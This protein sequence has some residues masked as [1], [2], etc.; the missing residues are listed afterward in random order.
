MEAKYIAASEAA[1]EQVWIRNFL[2]DLGV[3][4]AMS[5]SLDVYCDSNGAIAQAREPRDHHKSKHI[6]RRYH[7][8][9]QFVEA[10]D[11]K[12]CKVHM[13]AN[14]VDPLTKPLSQPKVEAHARAMGMRCFRHGDV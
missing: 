12:L 3:V 10:G 1:K 14:I 7:L 4:P 9:R 5:N 11:I 6:L 8:I 2:L 13:D